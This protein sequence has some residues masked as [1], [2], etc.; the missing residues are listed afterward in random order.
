MGASNASDDVES[1]IRSAFDM[2]DYD[3]AATAFI[4]YYGSE[5]VSFLAG[6][7]HGDTDE[8]A[9]VFSQF[10][11]DFWRGL[12][13]FKWSTSIRSW[14][15][16]LARNAAHRHTHWVGRQRERHKTYNSKSERFARAVDDLRTVTKKHL[17]TETKDQMRV[18]R[19]QLTE[20]EKTLLVL[21]VDRQLS[22][23]ELAA[24]MSGKGEQMDDTDIS[25]WSARL[26]QRFRTI[27]RRLKE[28]AIAEGLLARE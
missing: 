25:R 20:D 23:R 18:L 22:W 28:L 6:R 3:T 14:A 19:E 4:Q 17:R 11:E 5:I 15:Y 26:R 9:E 27:T 8:V 21:R 16:T 1:I 7:L 12:P 24:V 2:A 10:S 13:G